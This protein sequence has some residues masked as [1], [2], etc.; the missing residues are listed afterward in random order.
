MFQYQIGT[1]LVREVEKWSTPVVSPSENGI[2]QYRTGIMAHDDSTIAPCPPSAMPHIAINHSL[3]TFVEIVL[4]LASTQSFTC[5]GYVA[6][7]NSDPHPHA[8]KSS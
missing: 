1:L 5:T 2:G 4:L 6:V 7:L 8:Q 3:A